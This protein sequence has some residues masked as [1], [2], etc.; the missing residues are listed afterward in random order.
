MLVKRNDVLV[1]HDMDQS[2]LDFVLA[3]DGAS[4]WVVCMHMP[5]SYNNPFC[6]D[7][8]HIVNQHGNLRVHSQASSRIYDLYLHAWE[9]V[10]CVMPSAKGKRKR[11]SGWISQNVKGVLADPKFHAQWN[12]KSIGQFLNQHVEDNDL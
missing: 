10:Y 12:S 9:H 3:D 1:P 7:T 11:G 6:F 5:D 2:L 8:C 4:R